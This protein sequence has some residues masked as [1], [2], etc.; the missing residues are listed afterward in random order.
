VKVEIDGNETSN[1]FNPERWEGIEHAKD[2]DGSFTLHLVKDS[3]WV[4]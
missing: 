4:R 1:G 3:K 2:P